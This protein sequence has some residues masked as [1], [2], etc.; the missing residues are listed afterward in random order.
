[1]DSEFS[2]LFLVSFADIAVCFLL[3]ILVV[4]PRFNRW[5]GAEQ[6]QFEGAPKD[7]IHD[8]VFR[9]YAGLYFLTFVAIAFVISQVPGLKGVFHGAVSA[10][11]ADNPLAQ[12]LLLLGEDLG[13]AIL[14]PYLVIF[15][16]LLKLVAPIAKAD[17]R[18]RSFLLSSAR[19]P[20][21]AMNLKQQI[22]DALGELPL[23]H[24]GLD[25][26]FVSLEKR[27]FPDF[28][29]RVARHS[30]PLDS[31]LVAGRLLARNRYLV[32]LN[33]EFE[34]HY[35]G[36]NDLQR[37]ESRLLE[38]AGVLPAMQDSENTLAVQEYVNELETLQRTLCEM[39]A[40]NCVKSYPEAGDR[41]ALLKRYGFILKY[42]DNK[43]LD[44]RLP[45]A[46]V[47]LGTFVVTALC[48]M[49]FLALFDFAGVFNRRGDWFTE[50]RL[51]GW[52]IGGGLSY[53]LAVASGFY[54]NETLRNQFGDRNLATYI[55]AFLVAAMASMVFFALSREQFKPPFVLLA[56]NFGLLAIVVIRSRG[57]GLMSQRA[58]KKKATQIALQYA[59]ISAVL[60]V[61]IRITFYVFNRENWTLMGLLD[62]L[63]LPLFF[64]FGFVRGGAIAF[65]V[66]Y[67]FMDCERVYL[68]TARRKYPRI[69]V[70]NAVH[71]EIAGQP[72]DVVVL[73]LSEKGAMLRLNTQL[74][75]ETGV[76]A[77]DKVSLLF[78]F[79]RM[80]GQIMTVKSHQARVCFD[81]KR[82]AAEGIQHYIDEEMGLAV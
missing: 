59:L 17:E 70:G 35:P 27:G 58:V 2:T 40:K 10:L 42:M 43:E 66:A 78:S 22:L 41:N 73:D 13:Q 18:W 21:D 51:V 61:M 52:T 80:E 44:L 15:I 14:S 75:A 34:N 69:R 36:V 56:I 50:A 82:S 46:M 64:L 48:V 37:M 62:E 11:L 6:G 30:G 3:F 33:H 28:W 16:L 24:S 7:Y 29:D 32:R 45:V 8:R 68:Q 47:F 20:R 54:V 60:Q 65:L 77:G 67:V 76:Q 63:S 5:S 79:G 12:Q 71:C 9:E 74:N 53:V 31:P 26:V 39:L 55:F 19:V 23:T 72:A 1:M 38:I 25:A 57:R 4:L 49:F 81:S